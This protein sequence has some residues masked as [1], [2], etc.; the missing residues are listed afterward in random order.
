MRTLL[1]VLA[2][3]V[4]ACDA[5]CALVC[6]SDTE[7]IQQGTVPGYYCVNNSVCLPDC[8]RCGGNCVDTFFNCGACGK[9]CA[10]GEKCVA[11]G[12]VAGCPSGYSDCNGSCYDLAN[13]RVNCGACGRGCARDQ[14]CVDNVCTTSICG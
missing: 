13:D 1:L 8:Y 9:A 2:L 3:A 5:P 14:I 7:C 10:Q 11:G 4:S 12:C 6:S